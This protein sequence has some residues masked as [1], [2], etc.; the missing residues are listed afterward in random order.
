MASQTADLA[1]VVVEGTMRAGARYVAEKHLAVD[2]AAVTARMRDIVR[3]EYD[4]LVAT[5]KDALDGNMGGPM[6]RQIIN[7][8]CTSWGI[9]AVDNR[10]K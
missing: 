3:A 9:R 1:T 2:Y 8:Y 7:T 10:G 6:Y 5:L 4:E